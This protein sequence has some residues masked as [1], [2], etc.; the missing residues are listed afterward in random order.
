[1]LKKYVIFLLLLIISSCS[2]VR[3]TELKNF[4]VS[5]SSMQAMNRL[6]DPVIE[7]SFCLSST[8][9]HNELTGTFFTSQMPLCYRADVV[10]H[11]HPFY[12]EQSPNFI[13]LNAWNEYKKRY[14]N[15]MFGLLL[16]PSKLKVYVLE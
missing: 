15:D 9:I 4:Q 11:S 6:Y 12:T 13:D 5:D 2:S 8:G 3:Y 7:Q 10:I 1:M 16:G 14:G